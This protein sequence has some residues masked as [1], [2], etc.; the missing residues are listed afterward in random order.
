MIVWVKTKYLTFTVGFAVER[1]Q[2][3]DIYICEV[4]MM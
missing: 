3:A 2:D 4:G 1:K